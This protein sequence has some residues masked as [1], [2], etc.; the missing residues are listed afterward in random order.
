MKELVLLTPSIAENVEVS[1]VNL[2]I[3]GK[4]CYI[5]EG[6]QKSPISYFSERT[7][8]RSVSV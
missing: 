4:V 6:L 3:E 5:T 7:V 1:V 2:I 8:E